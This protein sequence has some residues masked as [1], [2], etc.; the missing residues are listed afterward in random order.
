MQVIDFATL[1]SSM[2]EGNGLSV[3]EAPKRCPS[4]QRNHPDARK[5]QGDAHKPGFHGLLPALRTG[6]GCHARSSFAALGLPGGNTKT[7]L[8]CGRSVA[9]LAPPHPKCPF[10]V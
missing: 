9:L 1:L 3:L 6:L 2:R 10:Q 4:S 5:R 8:T 7:D